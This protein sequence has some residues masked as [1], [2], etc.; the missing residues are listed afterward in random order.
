MAITPK[1]RPAADIPESLLQELRENLV[2]RQVSNGIALL[3]AS[4]HLFALFDPAQRN[5]AALVGAVAQWVDIGYSG[6]ELLEQL[7][8]HMPRDQRGK[9]P[10]ADYVHLRMAEGLLA[11]LRDHPDEALRNFDLVLT[12]QEEIQ[13]KE[14]VAIAH[15]W[16]ARCHRKKGEYDEALKRAGV[17]RELAMAL[18][19]PRMAAVMRVLESWLLFQ[20]GH[21]REAARILDQAEAALR[22]TDDD[23]TLGN[24]YSAHGRMIR[25]QGQYQQAVHFFTR[26]VEHFQK[27]NPQHRNLARSLA[28]IAYV[29][30][31][32]AAQMIRQMDTEAARRRKTNKKAKALPLHSRSTGGRQQ[33]EELR[34][35]AFANLEQAERIY[36]HHSHH[37]GIGNVLENRGL[38]HLDSG[39]LDLAAQEGARAYAVGR[40]ENDAIIMARA[41]LLQCKVEHAQLE[42]EIEGSTRTWEHVQAARDYAREAVEAAVHTQNQR[43]LARAYIWRGLTACHPAIHDHEDARHCMDKATAFIATSQDEDVWNEL[44]LL[45]QKVTTRGSVDSRLR[46]WTQ[47]VTDG[48]PFQKLTEEFAELVIPRV[49]E[50]EGRKVSR[51]AKVL[52]VSPK[53]V[54]RI[55]AKAGKSRK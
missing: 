21:G 34:A 8:Q 27:R 38:L 37:H 20:K 24:I 33:Y 45:K 30:R 29:Q 42:E 47:G 25:R 19:F 43:L 52:K 11:L 9:L 36:R 46:A 14:V 2:T 26:A 48:K 22:N 17:G 7:L 55:L 51:V 5:A 12:L 16:N 13:D 3:D 6:P 31:L 44:Q 50:N 23:I 41:R 53:K 10:V 39:E 32:I 40:E 1:A 49:W 28:N 54:R 35:S 15:F 4:A 18:G